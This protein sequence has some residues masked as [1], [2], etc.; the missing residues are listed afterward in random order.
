MFHGIPVPRGRGRNA[1]S[2]ARIKKN[3]SSSKFFSIPGF[4]ASDINR[5]PFPGFVKSHLQKNDKILFSAEKQRKD[6]EK[7]RYHSKKVVF[8]LPFSIRGP[9]ETTGNIPEIFP[10][11]G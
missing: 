1:G 4:V 9:A 3:H 8:L 2:R 7:E 5:D 10:V 6:K 11:A